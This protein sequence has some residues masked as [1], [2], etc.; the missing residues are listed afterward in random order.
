VKD[1]AISDVIDGRLA[2]NAL[3][4]PINPRTPYEDL[5]QQAIYDLLVKEWQ[6]SGMSE[7]LLVQ[8]MAQAQALVQFWTKRSMHYACGN[9][10]SLPSEKERL[11]YGEWVAPRVTEIQAMDFAVSMITRFEN[12]FLKNLRALRDL[13]RY[14]V[15]INNPKNVNF[16]DKQIIAGGHVN[17]TP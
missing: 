15:V 14:S 2:M 11:H 9:V 7:L 13:R 8:H 17:A 3:R 12:L 5:T 1:A 6:P 16:G 10:T 4:D